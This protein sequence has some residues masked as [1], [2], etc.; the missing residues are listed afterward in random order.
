MASLP[1]DA[2]LG[3]GRIKKIVKKHIK[4]KLYRYGVFIVICLEII[5]LLL[6]HFDLYSVKLYCILTHFVCALLIY[7]NNYSIKPKKLCVRK[8]W[9]YNTMF[10]YYLIGVFSLVLGVSYGFYSQIV[11]FVLLFISFILLYLSLKDE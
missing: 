5:S 8:K 9:A 2:F 7:N 11:N 6:K 10:I 4:P 1:K 3:G